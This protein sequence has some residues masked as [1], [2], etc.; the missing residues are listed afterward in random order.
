[1][2]AQTNLRFTPHTPNDLIWRQYGAGILAQYPE[3]EWDFRISQVPPTYQDYIR[4]RIGRESSART[5]QERA[6]GVQEEGALPYGRGNTKELPREAL[7]EH[8]NHATPL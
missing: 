4:A 1:M 8:R 2:T 3:E 6:G 7:N 5:A